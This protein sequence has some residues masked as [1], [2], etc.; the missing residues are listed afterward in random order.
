MSCK[1]YSKKDGVNLRRNISLA[2][3]V[4]W[5]EVLGRH[6]QPCNLARPSHKSYQMNHTQWIMSHGQET[7]A[8]FRSSIYTY[9]LASNMTSTHKPNYRKLLEILTPSFL[10]KR[11]LQFILSNKLRNNCWIHGFRL[12]L[13]IQENEQTAGIEN[14]LLVPWVV[15]MLFYCIYRPILCTCR[16]HELFQIVEIMLT[17]KYISFSFVIEFTQSKLICFFFVQFLQYCKRL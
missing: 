3:T 12:S 14:H 6:I 1:N 13:L 15:I 16:A 9:V 8:N 17:V 11:A 4:N 2:A 5:C 7:C 10:S